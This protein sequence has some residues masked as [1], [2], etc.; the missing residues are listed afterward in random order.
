MGLF[1]G[2]PFEQVQSTKKLLICHRHLWSPGKLKNQK[3]N[4]SNKMKIFFL[5]VAFTIFL[6]LNIIEWE[7]VDVEW[8]SLVNQAQAIKQA[9]NHCPVRPFEFDSCK[10]LVKKASTVSD[11]DAEE[12]CMA[13]GCRRGITDW[14][15][16]VDNVAKIHCGAEPW[17]FGACYEEV[18]RVSYGF[19]DEDMEY[20]CEDGD[21]V[22]GATEEDYLG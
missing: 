20:I 9:I 3:G 21:C 17:H 8:S 13:A 12:I 22:P 19:S 16:L 6:T 4:I 7:G 15:T 11:G 1:S 14:R 18:K 10:N 5:C 2:L